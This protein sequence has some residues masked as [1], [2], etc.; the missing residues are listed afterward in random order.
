MTIRLRCAEC[1]RKL[2][3]PDAARGRRV[4]CP[5]CGARFR[6]SGS[7]STPPPDEASRTPPRNEMSTAVEAEALSKPAHSEEDVIDALFAEMASSSEDTPE[8]A[9]VS[10]FPNLELEAPPA[11]SE[12][13][14]FEPLGAEEGE[15]EMVVEEAIEEEA[16]VEEAVEEEAVEITEEAE[17]VDAAEVPEDANSEE[18][19]AAALLDGEETEL[20]G[21]DELEGLDGLDEEA[22]VVE[23]AESE[24]EEEK[25][26]KKKD[27]KNF[28]S[29]LWPKSRS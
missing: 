18:A 20:D 17:S 22:E 9:A 28:L 19:A 12:E 16:V 23:E 25:R 15:E 1:R 8:Q 11:E 29:F 5:V 6:E 24:D 10:S 13:A 26:P 3:V 4:Q 7:L 27:K 21:L 14:G 2:K